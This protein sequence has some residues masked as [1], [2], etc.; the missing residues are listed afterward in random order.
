MQYKKFLASEDHPEAQ[1][2]YFIEKNTKGKRWVIPDIHG[3]NLTFRTLLQQIK[4]STEDQLFLLGDYINRG[5]DSAGVLR[6]IIT[7]LEKDYQVFPLRGNHEDMLLERHRERKAQASHN[8]TFL[9]SSFRKAKDFTDSD[10]RILPEFIGFFSNLPYYYE[11]DKFYLVHAGFDFRKPDPFHNF[12]EMIWIRDFEPNEKE[13][14]GKTIIHGHTPTA[15]SL[16]QFDLE[17]RR[18]AICLDNACVFKYASFDDEK[19][20]LLA[21]NLDSWELVIQKNID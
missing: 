19:G 17:A 2:S 4:L 16:I 13:L 15:L 14:N 9:P 20:N 21:L 18:L 10:K 6:T 12:E 5:K 8:F 7:L 3:C 1:K 11:L